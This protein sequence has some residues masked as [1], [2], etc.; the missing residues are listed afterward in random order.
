M[1]IIAQ[2]QLTFSALREFI[3]RPQCFVTDLVG[4]SLSVDQA[5][6]SFKLRIINSSLPQQCD[7]TNTD[8]AFKVG[9]TLVQ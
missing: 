4:Q 2:I 6:D 5:E 7:L 8:V 3:K 1:Y 9:T